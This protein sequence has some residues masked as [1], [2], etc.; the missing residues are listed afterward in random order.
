M[1]YHLLLSTDFII[2]FIDRI[3]WYDLL[4]ARI[5]YLFFFMCVINLL[6]RK[7]TLPSMH[8]KVSN[9]ELNVCIGIL[10]TFLSIMCRV[11][12]EEDKIVYLQHISHN[13]FFV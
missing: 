7:Q 4:I 1:F 3:I 2:C 9:Y 12:K 10:Y 13:I 11:K 5:I 6:P 8:H